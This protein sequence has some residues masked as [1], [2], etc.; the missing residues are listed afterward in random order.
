M[1]L[2]LLHLFVSLTLFGGDISYQL[3]R[4]LERAWDKVQQC[5]YIGEDYHFLRY[6]SKQLRSNVSGLIST[7]NSIQLTFPCFIL[8]FFFIPP[9]RKRG[10]KAFSQ[11]EFKQWR[12]KPH[13]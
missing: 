4:K 6:G 10:T 9:C 7:D 3:Y 8:G 2:M 5:D 11:L 13:T 12:V 1:S